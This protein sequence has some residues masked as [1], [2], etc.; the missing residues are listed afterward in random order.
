MFS[1]DKAL[2][3]DA[4]LWTYDRENQTIK[5]PFGDEIIAE[6]QELFSSVFPDLNLDASTPQGQLITSL[7][8]GDLAIISY[9]QSC[10]NGFFLGGEGYFLDLWAWNNYRI[11]RK[12]GIK[13][14]VYIEIK[15]TPSTLINNDFKVTD[16]SHKYTLQQPQIISSDGSVTALFIADELDDFQAPA[17]TIN[18]IQTAVVGVD[19]VNN[20]AQ[21]TE[22]SL[23]ETDAELFQRCVNFGST[24]ANASFKSI[25]AN[26]KALD[27]VTKVNGVENISSET[28]TLQG[29]ELPSHS[30]ALIV[31]GGE[32]TDIANAI[33]TTR[34]SGAGMVGDIEVEVELEGEVYKYKFSRPKIIDL[35]CE[36]VIINK[37]LIDANYADYVKNAVLY[38]INNLNIGTLITQPNLA[39]SI[40]SQVSGFE[41]V[42]VKFGLKDGTL[43]YDYI[44]LNGDEEA[45]IAETSINVSL[46]NA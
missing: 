17:N 2:A 41:I 24:A 38:Y 25:V 7:A 16:G 39:N 20:P 34:A 43:G 3:T 40:K 23:K 46:Q 26:V 6:Y 8:Q 15:G 14:Q 22:P 5:F 9:L 45:L 18:Q 12:D 33:F 36:V 31:K 11:T 30:F 4:N 29:I 37:N 35:A 28:V 42:D 21:A 10:I 1:I 19:S 13:S 44:Q 32:R 27:G